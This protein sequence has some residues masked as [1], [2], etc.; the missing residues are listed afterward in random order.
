MKKL[1]VVTFL[2]SSIIANNTFAVTE[3]ERQVILIEKEAPAP[4]K[5]YL[6]PEDKALKFRKEL[7]ELDTLKEMTTSYERSITLY[8]RNEDLHN[9]RVNQLM[10]QNDKL[11]KAVY[12][13]QDRD[14]FENWVWFGFGMLAAGMA[15]RL[16][17]K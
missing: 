2:I 8:K 11:A 16:N 15:I 7:L 9:Y 12:Q 17:S 3:A 14:S 5:G 6:F 10:D 13:A 4:F 1:T